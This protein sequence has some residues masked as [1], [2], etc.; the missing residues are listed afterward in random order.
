M[1]HLA[2]TPDAWPDSS[3]LQGESEGLPD[4]MLGAL[5]YFDAESFAS[6]A[7]ASCTVVMN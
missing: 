7:T 5:A 2:G 6:S 1:C 4:D 3:I